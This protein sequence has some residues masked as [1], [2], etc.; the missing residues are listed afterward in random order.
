MTDEPQSNSHQVALTSGMIVEI[1][2]M[3]VV[4]GLGLLTGHFLLKKVL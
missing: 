3:L 4:F 2:L 1:I